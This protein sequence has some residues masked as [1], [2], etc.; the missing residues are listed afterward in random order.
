MNPVRELKKIATDLQESLI[1]ECYQGA[2]E[3][4]LDEEEAVAH[5]L[6]A[7]DG[8]TRDLVL[9]IVRRR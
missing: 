9:K 3:E 8:L 5:V 1:R 7:I 4:G 2:L 6:D